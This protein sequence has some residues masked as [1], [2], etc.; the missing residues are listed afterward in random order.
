[1][2]NININGQLTVSRWRISVVRVLIKNNAIQYKARDCWAAQDAL[3]FRLT[4]SNYLWLQY[5]ISQDKNFMEKCPE[6]SAAIE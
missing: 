1:M 3:H 2:T 6:C 5:R 4:S